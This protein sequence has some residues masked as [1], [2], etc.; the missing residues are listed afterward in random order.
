VFI[1]QYLLQAGKLQKILPEDFES[2]SHRT[3]RLLDMLQIFTPNLITTNSAV[4]SQ[5]NESISGICEYETSGSNVEP[6][7]SS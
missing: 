7:F 4:I 1:I 3:D 6:I 2:L 5:T